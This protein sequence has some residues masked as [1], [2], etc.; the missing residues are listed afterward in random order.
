LPRLVILINAEQRNQDCIL[1]S[2]VR[3]VRSRGQAGL[4]VDFVATTLLGK[5]VDLVKIGL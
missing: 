1:Q 2:G 3:D 5:T 4:N